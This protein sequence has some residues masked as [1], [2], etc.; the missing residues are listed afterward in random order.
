MSKNVDSNWRIPVRLHISALTALIVLALSACATQVERLSPGKDVEA[1]R[2]FVVAG[3]L[4]ELNSIRLDDQIKV[5]YVNDFFV[6]IPMRRD[7]YLAEFRGRCSELRER[8]WVSDMV[9]VR[10]NAKMLYS[11][12]DT[13][14]GCV[15]GKLYAI[16][17]S[18]LAELKSLGDAPGNG[19]SVSQEN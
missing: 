9:D 10:V 1:V 2:D 6:V 3:E 11:D 17:E 4:Q 8:Q 16:S 18:Q 13:I 7:Q 19:L 14:R 15:I 12:Y 5:L